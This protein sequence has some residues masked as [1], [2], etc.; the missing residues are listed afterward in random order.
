VPFLDPV[1]GTTCKVQ[2]TSVT[3]VTYT[4]N[5]IPTPPD[6]SFIVSALANEVVVT[7]EYPTDP[8]VVGSGVLLP[9]VAHADD[10]NPVSMPAQHTEPPQPTQTQEAP[11]PPY[12][13]SVEKLQRFLAEAMRTEKDAENLV[14][15]A[16]ADKR[17][18]DN[19]VTLATTFKQEF[20]PQF[21]A[22][23]NE[24]A[25]DLVA[26]AKNSKEQLEHN[27]SVTAKEKEEIETNLAKAEAYREAAANSRSF[28][29]L[30]ENYVAEAKIY[31]EIFTKNLAKAE[32]SLAVADEKVA[33]AVANRDAAVTEV[34]KA[35]G[36]EVD[37]AAGTEVDKAAGKKIEEAWK[38]LVSRSLVLIRSGT[39]G[40]GG[41]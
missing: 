32:A 3:T 10:K 40:E 15:K 24:D 8:P 30:A 9:A 22:E 35:A 6:G 33:S 41:S 23:A 39:G 12:D 27:S 19:L 1:V 31:Q 2:E 20:A 13:F 11:G 14:T 5:G 16:R 28:K 36:T 29:E 25:E 18:A 17:D 38:E 37:K 7:N 26:A 21:I 34:D 4:H